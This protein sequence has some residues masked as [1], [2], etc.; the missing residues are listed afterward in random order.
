MEMLEMIWPA[1]LAV[2]AGAAAFGWS[3][4]KKRVDETPT[5][6]D[7]A[8]VRMIEEVLSKRRDDAPSTHDDKFK[9]MKERPDAE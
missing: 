8:L 5:K 6:I 2:L 1:L 7:D 9:M 3:K 4:L